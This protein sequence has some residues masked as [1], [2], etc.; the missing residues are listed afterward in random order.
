MKNITIRGVGVLLFWMISAISF[1]QEWHHVYLPNTASA[2]SAVY[3]SIDNGFVMG[4][5]TKFGGAPKN[6]IILKTTVNG[7]LIWW[8]TISG[9]NDFTG[10]RDLQET[11]NGGCIV[12][13]VT[14]EQSQQHNP[15]ILKLNPCFEP[16]W[17][18]IF[19]FPTPFDE[20]GASVHPVPGGYLVL[21]HRY[22]DNLQDRVWVYKLDNNGALIWKQLYCQSDPRISDELPRTLNLIQDNSFLINGMCYYLEGNQGNS[23]LKPFI[24]KSDS[25]GFPLWER[26]WNFATPYDSFIGEGVTSVTDNQGLIYT[27]ARHVV[28]D[29]SQ[30]GDKPALLRTSCIGAVEAFTDIVPGSIQG[31][32]STVN[33]F[34]DSTLAVGVSWTATPWIQGETGVY[35]IDR[36]GNYISH[37][38]LITSEYSFN[39]AL[40]TSDNKLLLVGGFFT[41]GMRSHAFKLNSNLDYDSLYDNPVIYDSLCPY[42]IITDT[43]PLNCLLVGEDEHFQNPRETRFTA[44]PNPASEKISIKMPD[45]LI[46]NNNFTA[47]RVVTS[48][49]QWDKT[50][51]EV[52]NQNGHCMHRKEIPFSMKV[53]EFPL[54]GYS[55]GIYSIRLM[56]HGVSAGQLVFI[57]I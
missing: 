43:I 10:I 50:I 38:D 7:N 35:K 46:I 4:G 29:P 39:D 3:E 11:A 1:S 30:Q 19:A 32:A 42:A 33:W 13:G 17:C 41:N 28:T 23:T 5:E 12:T 6:G 27:A 47:H 56:Y 20:W 48:V 51:I 9:T 2:L 55:P 25:L 18:R 44:Y 22:G 14:G 57:K 53:V 49:Q 40:V 15:F 16:E 36:L 26:V 37:R 52:Y 34:S 31:V 45:E 21:F 54:H 8:K 24:I